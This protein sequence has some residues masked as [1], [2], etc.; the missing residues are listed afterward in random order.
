MTNIFKVRDEANRFLKAI[1]EYFEITE[2]F[3]MTI[4]KCKLCN[5]YLVAGGTMIPIRALVLQHLVQHLRDPKVYRDVIGGTKC[6]EDR[7][8]NN[9]FISD[10][11]ED[12]KLK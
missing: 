1:E 12:E 10:E 3:D 4:V 8:K 7:L 6:F 5:D 2:N 9:E 11:N